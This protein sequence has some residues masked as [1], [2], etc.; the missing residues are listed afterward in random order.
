MNSARNFNDLEKAILKTVAF[1]DIFDYPL[2]LIEIYKW[3]YQPDRDYQLSEITQ[4]LNSPNL[5]GVRATKNGF[6]FLV[7]RESIIQTRLERYQIAEKKF[8]IALRTVWY[9]RWLAFV[10]MIAIC[11]TFGYNNTMAESDIDFFIIVKKGRLWWCRLLIVL[12]T[13]IL[14]VRHHGQKITDRICLSFYLADDHLNLTDIALKPTD[15]YLAFWLATL[16]PIYDLDIYQDFLKANGWLNYYL[17]DFYETFLN[18]R[19]KIT[20]NS[21]IKFSRGF[22]ELVLG[23]SVGDW[24]EKLA[25]RVQIKKVKGYFG[26]V[27]DQANT[28]VVITS[29]I[30]K[31]HKIDRRQEYQLLW[32]KKL[33]GLG[34]WPS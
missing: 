33:K 19:R 8:K 6:Y 29:S 28:N 32:Q 25:Q 3:L 23:G 7:N 1:F 10:K 24:L 12:L 22:D 9:L 26:Q 34:L 27:A 17:P 11:N 13:T 20:D 15:P 21:Y 2:V 30:L 5:K 31:F 4:A 18:D 16:A 14:R